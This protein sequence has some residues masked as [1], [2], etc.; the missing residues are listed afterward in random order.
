MRAGTTTRTVLPVKK[1]TKDI[2]IR[3]PAH[4]PAVNLLFDYLLPNA[5]FEDRFVG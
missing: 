4:N 3:P 2:G 1:K 5:I